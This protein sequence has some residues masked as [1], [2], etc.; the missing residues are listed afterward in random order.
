[1][2]NGVRAI[3]QIGSL[4]S[5]SGV[6]SGISLDISQRL[7]TATG[8]GGYGTSRSRAANLSDY[9][10]RGSDF[11]NAFKP[12]E[13]APRGSKGGP[14]DPN[15]GNGGNGGNGTEGR[16]G[17]TY[18]FYI[19]GEDGKDGNDGRGGYNG[20]DGAPGGIGIGVVPL[21]PVDLKPLW[22]AIKE[23]QEREDC[24]DKLRRRI[25]D[26]ETWK[27]KANKRIKDLEDKLDDKNTVEC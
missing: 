15:G 16:N 4:L 17:T 23:L 6:P 1:M 20:R 22:D 5:Q 27:K 18:G 14:S 12:P 21:F 25:E 19:P 7:L 9:Y 3:E 24:C 8:L 26:L 13:Q 10:S 11:Y 2:S